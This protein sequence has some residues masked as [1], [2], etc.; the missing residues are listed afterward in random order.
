MNKELAI[1]GGTPAFE[2][3]VQMQHFLPSW[4][5]FK[6]MIGGIFDRRYYTN[7]G[8]LALE[9]EKRFKDFFGAR[10]AMYMSN[11]GIALMISA[12]ALGLKGKVIIPAFAH[13][14]LAQ[15]VIWAGAQPVFCDV[16][17]GTAHL[18][19]DML[20][21]MIDENTS[22]ILGAN[23]FGG[24][25]DYDAIERIAARHS[26]DTFYL[27]DDAIGEQYKN[28]K[29]GN[30]GKLEIFSLHESKIINAINGCVVTCNDDLLAEKI[31]HMRS[32]YGLGQPTTV[33]FTGNGRM[34][35]IV[36]GMALLGLEKFD[37]HV[38]ENKRVFEEYVTIINQVD[39]MEVYQP[40]ES[41]GHR[42]YQKMVVKINEAEFGLNAAEV[43]N[44][45]RA[46]NFFTSP[47]A[48]YSQNALPPYDALTAFPRATELAGSMLEFPMSKSLID[49]QEFDKLLAVLKQ[50]KAAVNK[51][52]PRLV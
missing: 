12:R 35:E 14:S 39:G 47:I 19:P 49:G 27:S 41:I 5:Q 30:F 51:I 33:P 22:A 18:D 37:F 29:I 3:N 25:C 21:S 45:L 4:D 31:R 20:E 44:V 36:A 23:L 24:S 9:F 7:H 42:N 15:A 1:L 17:T 38:Q 2:Q 50:A 11:S 26:I 46:E 32:S 52:K 10:N 28:Q 43:F 40:A 13:V 48:H 8:P 34:S 16:N 6:E